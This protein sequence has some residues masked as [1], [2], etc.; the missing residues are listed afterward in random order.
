[1]NFN[2]LKFNTNY[3]TSRKE[4]KEK[5][6]DRIAVGQEDSQTIVSVYF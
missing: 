1:M 3:K 6:V 5:D 4:S 2:N